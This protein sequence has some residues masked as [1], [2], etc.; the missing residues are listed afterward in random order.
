MLLISSCSSPSPISPNPK[1]EPEKPPLVS[2][3]KITGIDTWQAKALGNKLTAKIEYNNDYYKREFK[4]DLDVKEA[5]TE[6]DNFLFLS[7]KL[8]SLNL[9][10]G[11]IVVRIASSSAAATVGLMMREG[12][13]QGGKYVF[14][15]LNANM[16]V[17]KS[18]LQD[19]AM[20]TE[21]SLRLKGNL[22]IWLK[23]KRMNNDF[24]GYYSLD[25]S[26]WKR[27]DSVTINMKP[28]LNLGIAIASDNKARF[29]TIL[30]SLSIHKNYYYLSPTGNDNAS[31]SIDAPWQ[32]FDY[33]VPRLR[34]G[35]VLVLQ[36][37]IYKDSNSGVLEV[38][39][40]SKARNGS[41]LAPITVRAQHERRALIRGE[42][43]NYPVYI[44]KRSNWV[45]EGIAA[46]NSDRGGSKA[47]RGHVFF[48]K[49]DKTNIAASSNILLKRVLA[50]WP[51]RYGNNHGILVDYS[52]DIAIEEAEIYSF[53]RHGID[54]YGSNRVVIRR[55]YINSNNQA[56]RPGASSRSNG[57]S[58]LT[59][60]GDE[61][62]ALY[63]S[64]NSI[65]E[66][67][68]A[69]NRQTGF[70]VNGGIWPANSTT[71]NRFVA[72]NNSFLGII[73]Y[74]AVIGAGVN[75]REYYNHLF[76]T[77]GNRFDNLLI[78]NPEAGEYDAG[79]ALNIFSVPELELNH[80]TIYT[81]YDGYAR[82]PKIKSFM[83]RERSDI[84]CRELTV[85]QN[86][87][88][89]KLHNS[90]IW[91]EGKQ[92][93]SSQAFSLGSKPSLNLIE[94]NNIYGYGSAVGADD[95]ISDSS[96]EFKNNLVQEP[97]GFKQ[98]DNDVK[99]FLLWLPDASN[100]KNKADDGSDIGAN[101]RKRYHNGVLT[102]EDLWKNGEFPCGAEIPDDLIANSQ[103]YKLGSCR[104]ISKRLHVT[105]P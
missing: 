13:K 60:G 46:R 28:E 15:A 26:T 96:G 56:D 66:N 74:K 63:G 102:N 23:L 89:F 67:S 105:G 30:D 21:S 51:N 57:R 44:D 93:G 68:I 29:K 42:G 10:D 45:I 94:N 73:S 90:I 38:S 22:P 87:C 9:G 77:T 84:K 20:P 19:A 83:T 43:K 1:P 39:E 12:L 62:V 103:L 33:A 2:Q 49:G 52:Q 59:N 82:A 47:H 18:R 16:L 64:S 34:P 75:S 40:Y 25:G 7:N 35:D 101:I 92:N 104:L 88:S 80:L 91:A 72:R 58:L 48:I 70:V 71:S 79:R 24:S 76:Q 41:E 100:M 86:K 8:S 54:A 69:E 97:S 27:L 11:E 99:R 65:V 14:I 85:N 98:Y 50:Y 78:I 55:A 61:A 4:I 17:F 81:N 31:G 6:P 95:D 37:G 5:K 36:D 32:S 3:V 53:H